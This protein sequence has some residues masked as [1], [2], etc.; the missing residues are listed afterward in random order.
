MNDRPEVQNLSSGSI[1]PSRRDSRDLCEKQREREGGEEGRGRGI[2][3]F[4]CKLRRPAE[5]AGSHRH[6]SRQ[7]QLNYNFNGPNVP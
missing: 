3:N 1:R 5:R 6:D 7:K 4:E 2:F